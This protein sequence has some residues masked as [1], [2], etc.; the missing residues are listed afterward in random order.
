MTTDHASHRENDIP[1]GKTKAAEGGTPRRWRIRRI[2]A[3]LSLLLGTVALLVGGLELAV[4]TFTEIV[5][6]LTTA[7]ADIG[8]RYMRSFTDDVYVDEAERKVRFRFNRDGFRGPDRD[9]EKPTGVCRI[10]VLGDSEIAA[11]SVD[12]QDTMVEQLERLLSRSHSEIEWDVMNFGVAGSSPGQEMVLYE[13]LVR[14]YDPDIVLMGFT[15]GNDL[16]DNCNRLSNNPRIYFDLDETGALVQQPFSAKRA[17]VSRWLNRYS[18]FYVWQKHAFR[19]ARVRVNHAVKQINPGQW[20]Y[21]ADPNEDVDHAW[22]V[23]EAILAEFKRKVEADGRMFAVVMIP[24]AE[25]IHRDYYDSVVVRAGDDGLSFDQNHPERKVAE[26]CDRA[27][28]AFI[29]PVA[30]Y[31]HEAPTGLQSKRDEWLFQLGSGHTNE[32][33]NRLTAERVHAFLTEGDAALASA[34]FV[35]RLR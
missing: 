20:I 25:Q 35:T 2:S 31:R 7:D 10:A 14:K 33:G 16:A 18:R 32:K 29:S 19:K 9:V 6:P 5:P 22:K 24:G 1:P 8:K 23:T 17:T 28:A 13:K 11:L 27:G 30:D 21:C 26:I 34:P 15:V 3:R 4:R 12:E